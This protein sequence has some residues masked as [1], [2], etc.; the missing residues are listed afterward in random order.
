MTTQMKSRFR[1]TSLALRASVLPAPLPTKLA[2][3]CND[4]TLREDV[5]I[6]PHLLEISLVG[7]KTPV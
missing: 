6:T 3:L 1:W 2:D 4:Q 7:L 5:W